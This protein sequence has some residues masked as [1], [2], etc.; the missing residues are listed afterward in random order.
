MKITTIRTQTHS[1]ARLP[2]ITFT[3]GGIRNTTGETESDIR[4]DPATT[5]LVLR[6]STSDE[7]VEQLVQM[8]SSPS[9]GLK[10]YLKCVVDTDPVQTLYLDKAFFDGLRRKAGDAVERTA[11]TLRQAGMEVEALPPHFGLAAEEVLRTEGQI[12]PDVIIMDVP[13]QTRLQKVFDRAF[14]KAVTKKAKAM[15]VTL[16][17][18]QHQP[19]L[20]P[21]RLGSVSGR[22]RL[23]TALFIGVIVALWMIMARQNADYWSLNHL[24]KYSEWG[25]AMAAYMAVLW[26]LVAGV[27]IS[28]ALTL[29]RSQ[30]IKQVSS[31]GKES[32]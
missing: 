30:A 23:G 27:A 6:P 4:Q 10:V 1:G 14:S 32:Q 12:H 9:A 16:L 7:S 13:H 28:L 21:Q 31:K 29:A 26:G 19:K 20:Q 11:E 15:V 17:D 8:A 3:S 24:L 5:L 18:E 22:V 2:K 25:S